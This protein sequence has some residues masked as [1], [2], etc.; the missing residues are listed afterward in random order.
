[1]CYVIH[2]GV[3]WNFGLRM[4]DLDDSIAHVVTKEK[5]AWRLKVYPDHTLLSWYE[6]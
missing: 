2:H 6:A 1:M 3:H 5:S 4:N